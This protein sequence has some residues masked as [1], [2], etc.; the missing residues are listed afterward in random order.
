MLGFVVRR[1]AKE[2]GHNPT[3]DEF[4]VWANNQTLEGES[5][6]IF[7]RAI[8]TEAARVMLR[9]LDRLVTVRS[10]EIVVGQQDALPRAPAPAACSAEGHGRAGP[11]LRPIPIRARV[12]AGTAPT[13]PS[14][15]RR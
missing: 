10:R 7:G 6:H 13:K 5:Y 9:S 2:L 15:P 11:V 1:C 3:A 12:R 8:S 14:S 4:A